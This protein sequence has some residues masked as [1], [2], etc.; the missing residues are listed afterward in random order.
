MA[1][2]HKKGAAAPATR[3]LRRE[4]GILLL[5]LVGTPRS[6]DRP[7]TGGAAREYPLHSI[8]SPTNRGRA[9]LT[10]HD[11]DAGPARR[12]CVTLSRMFPAT[13]S[14]RWLLVIAALLS[15]LAPLA[16]TLENFASYLMLA[17]PRGFPDGLGWLYSGL[18]PLK[19]GAFTF[20]Y[21]YIALLVGLI[22]APSLE[23]PTPRVPR[24]SFLPSTAH[25]PARSRACANRRGQSGSCWARLSASGCKPSSST[26]ASARAPRSINTSASA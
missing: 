5:S 19:F 1:Q 24:P 6:L 3:M 7:R 9:S 21:P 18:A 2:E 14:G 15:V 12:G 22:A 10:S 25:R 13:H 11:W 26:P 16:H 17:D 23:A 4:T 8:A 20:A